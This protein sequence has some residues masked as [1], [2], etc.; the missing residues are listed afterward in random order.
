MIR[1]TTAVV[2]ISSILLVA[3]A[4]QAQSFRNARL[5]QCRDAN[6]ERV[7]AVS[8]R[9]LN[10]VGMA[11]RVRGRPVMLF[12][13]VIMRRFQP[14]TRTFWFYHECA[15]HVLGH[16][17]GHRPIS[18]ERDADCWA[19]RQMKRRGLLTAAKLST[20]KRDLYSLNGDGYLYLPGPQRAAHV[21]YCATGRRTPPQMVRRR[22]NRR[23]LPP[24]GYRPGYRRYRDQQVVRRYRPNRRWTN[25]YGSEGP[26]AP[27][28]RYRTRRPAYGPSGSGLQ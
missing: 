4:A 5:T 14:A 8:T 27:M 3:G 22:I 18:R 16:S 20:I 1:S 13:P 11:G 28:A 25:R 15:H 17:L 10:N 24:A 9:R 21:G 23:G 26:V 12:N 6:G 7:L 2:A 19:I